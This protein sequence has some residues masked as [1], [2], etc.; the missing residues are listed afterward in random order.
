VERV[1]RAFYVRGL[2][3]KYD[4]IPVP[5]LGEFLLERDLDGRMENFLN[6]CRSS[7]I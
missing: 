7:D 6:S 4:Y 1:H 5:T 2:G 3:I